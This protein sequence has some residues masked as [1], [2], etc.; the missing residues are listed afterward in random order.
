MRHFWIYLVI[1]AVI[2]ALMIPVFFQDMRLRC[3]TLQSPGKRVEVRLVELHRPPPRKAHPKPE[4]AQDVHRAPKPTQTAPPKISPV[5]RVYSTPEPERPQ[6]AR[7]PSSRP[8]IDVGSRLH[9]LTVGTGAADA[10]VPGDGNLSPG[11]IPQPGPAIGPH[12]GGTTPVLGVETPRAVSTP[13]PSPSPSPSPPP[14]PPP[15]PPRAGP[16]REAIAVS[17]PTPLIPHSLRMQNIRSSVRVRFDITAGGSCS[18]TLL[19][20]S[21]NSELDAMTL[22]TLQR[23]QWEPALKNGAPVFS[24]QRVR[25]EFLV[26]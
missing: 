16:T 21:G 15:P 11:M 20:S 9:L 23:W 8:A 17:A 7:M 24:V 12:E 18:V 13:S 26:E 2:N 3:S 6:K 4:P 14:P 1:S 10:G 5:A 25:I 19:T 22:E